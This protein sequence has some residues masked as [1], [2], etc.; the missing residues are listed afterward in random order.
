VWL[1]DAPVVLHTLRITVGREGVS[2]AVGFRR[3]GWGLGGALLG[4]A[5]LVK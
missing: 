3:A 5:G 4:W 2:G 1:V